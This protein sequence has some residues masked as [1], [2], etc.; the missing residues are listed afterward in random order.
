M[1]FSTLPLFCNTLWT[2]KNGFANFLVFAKIFLRKI[3]NSRVRLVI[4]YAPNF[5]LKNL[6][7][8]NVKIIAFRY[9]FTSKFFSSADCFE[10]LGEIEKIAN[11]FSLLSSGLWHSKKG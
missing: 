4:E 1:E 7:F 2:G 5:C 6:L 9:E 11:C 10:Y 3:Q 8:L